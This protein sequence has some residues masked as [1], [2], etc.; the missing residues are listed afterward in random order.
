MLSDYET[1]V[2]DLVRDDAARL[3]LAEKDRAIDAAVYRYSEDKPQTK[4]QDVTPE[5]ANLLPLPAAWEAGFSTI[6]ALEHPKG[7]IP[8]V[9]L[10][11]GRYQVYDDGA[12]KKIQVFDAV[13]VAASS[14]RVG[15]T[16]KHVVSAVADTV[17]V[18]HR[19]PVACLAAASLCDQ[20][21]SFY[22]GGTDS[23]IQADS[24]ESRSKAQEYAS[25]AAKLRKRYHDELGIE[26]KRA[27]PAGTVVQV[28]GG[29]SWGG[30]RLN[31]PALVRY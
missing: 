26:D 3:S 20:L 16:I 22:A 11:Q 12:A 29:D 14:V 28:K 27:M 21:A 8:P 25:R 15:Y 9:Y 4:V 24:V 19:E 18:A 13:A 30:D 17:P 1:L 31:H 6:L 23:T 2:A 10:D 7:E 5:T